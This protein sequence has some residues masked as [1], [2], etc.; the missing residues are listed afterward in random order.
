M[1][2]N[3]I[4]PEHAKMFEDIFGKDA[5]GDNVQIMDA[6]IKDKV[7]EMTSP[8]PLRIC[9]SF[10]KLLLTVFTKILPIAV[11]SSIIFKEVLNNS[12]DFSTYTSSLTVVVKY[13]IPKIWYMIVITVIFWILLQILNYLVQFCI[14]KI[15][16]I[17]IRKEIEKYQRATEVIKANLDKKDKEEAEAKRKEK[18]GGYTDEEIIAHAKEAVRLEEEKRKNQSEKS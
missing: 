8:V 4:D 3:Q 5:K 9:D 14:V 18:N 6:K 17:R 16:D 10:F 13:I 12:Y 1:K 11:L 7:K 2:N 15:Y